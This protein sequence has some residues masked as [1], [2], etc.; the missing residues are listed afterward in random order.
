MADY[1]LTY[2]IYVGI[3]AKNEDQANERLL[4]IQDMLQ[5]VQPDNR[6]R[7]WLGDVEFGD[8]EIEEA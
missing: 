2:T 4:A 7:P 8:M 1:T 6:K 3:T 5:M